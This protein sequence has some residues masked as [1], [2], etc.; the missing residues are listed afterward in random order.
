MA[1]DADCG[2]GCTI[3]QGLPIS[4]E[5][6]ALANWQSRKVAA[7]CMWAHGSALNV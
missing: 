2:V 7:S 6:P 3:P 1:L 4:S 5:I